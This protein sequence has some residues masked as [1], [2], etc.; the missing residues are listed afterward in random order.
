VPW[1]AAGMYS[2]VCIVDT[3]LTTYFERIYYRVVLKRRARKGGE[4]GGEGRK[5]KLM[6]VLSICR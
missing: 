1:Y 2:C 6:Y 3:P 4:E 5:K